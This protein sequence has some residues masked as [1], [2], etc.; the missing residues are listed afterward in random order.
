MNLLE[1]RNDVLKDIKKMTLFNNP[2]MRA[3]ISHKE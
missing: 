2:M 3:V 1:I